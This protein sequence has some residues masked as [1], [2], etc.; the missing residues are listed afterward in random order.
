MAITENSPALKLLRGSPCP[1]ARFSL[2]GFD[3]VI[4][5][6]NEDQGRVGDHVLGTLILEGTSYAIHGKKLATRSPDLLEVLTPR[7]LE[8]AL[9]IA[10]G[11]K[12][13]AIA[14]RLRI[15]FHTVRIHVGHI[16]AKLGLRKQTELAAQIATR[17]G[18]SASSP[19]S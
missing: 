6:A 11:E 7:E 19:R 1:L 2:S 8:I 5:P 3:C 17:F 16:Y 13:K 10:A 15:S 18:R 12:S 14:R 4:V 9:L